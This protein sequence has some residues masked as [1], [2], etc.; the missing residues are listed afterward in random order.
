MKFGVVMCVEKTA[1][2][3]WKLGQTY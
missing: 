3:L 1:A 2:C